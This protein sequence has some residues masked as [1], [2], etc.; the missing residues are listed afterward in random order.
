[1]KAPMS[2]RVRSILKDE[3][4]SKHL[5][6]ALRECLG[7]ESPQHAACV[8]EVSRTNTGFIKITIPKTK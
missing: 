5:V 6:G 7:N 8:D 2:E 4:D 3:N 1:M